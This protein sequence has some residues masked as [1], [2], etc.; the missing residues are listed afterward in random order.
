MTAGKALKL[1]RAVTSTHAR[2]IAES[3]GVSPSLI[4]KFEGGERELDEK[5]LQ[6]IVRD[7]GLSAEAWDTLTA[8]DQESIPKA[9]R[10][11][12]ALEVID[13]AEAFS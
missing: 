8:E 3:A 9:R 1:L 4:A 2:I 12:A 13:L 10:V 11:R 7:L 5:V 6:R